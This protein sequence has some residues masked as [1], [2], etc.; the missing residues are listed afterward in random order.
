MDGIFDVISARA[1]KPLD[2][3]FSLSFPHLGVK[4]ICLFP[5]GENFASEI[6]V[7]EEKFGF[8]YQLFPSKTHDKSCI[9]S[10]SKLYP[11]N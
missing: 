9:V 11:K 10:V 2:E 7:A 6:A 1:L 5:K 8:E 3:L 4:S